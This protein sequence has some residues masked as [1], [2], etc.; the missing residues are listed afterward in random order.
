MFDETIVEVKPQTKPNREKTINV[1]VDVDT[2]GRKYR[3]YCFVER[4]L[5]PIDKG[6]Q[7]AHS[8]VEYS[9]LYSEN[10]DYVSWSFSDKTI[11]L[12]NGGTVTDLSDICKELKDWNINFSVFREEDLGNIVTS[13]A[14]LVDNKVI[15]E[16]YYHYEIE[17]KQMEEGDCLTDEEEQISFLRDLIK[18]KHLAR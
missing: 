11:V 5:S 18:S 15:D 6:I 2:K 16:E 7:A 12:L 9:N 14:V 1:E 4:H 3:M 13:V 8:I 17:E 10:V